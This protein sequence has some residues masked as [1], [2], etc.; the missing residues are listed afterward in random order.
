ME[1]LS[2]HVQGSMFE[3][4]G[5]KI[6]NKKDK[7]GDRMVVNAT[8]ATPVVVIYD[9]DTVTNIVSTSKIQTHLLAVNAT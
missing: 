3:D 2:I 9:E 4:V 8:R 6:M 7:N 5:L 1:Q